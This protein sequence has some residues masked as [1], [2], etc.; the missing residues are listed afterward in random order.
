MSKL[1]LNAGQVTQLT[2]QDSNLQQA[3]ADGTQGPGPTDVLSPIN[4]YQR[5]STD[6]QKLTRDTFKM[7][8][9][10]F[11]VA[12]GLPGLTTTVNYRK[13]DGVSNGTLTFTNGILTS[14]T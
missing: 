14:S 9:A 3:F 6:L 1:T 4:G 12:M 13:S 2:T 8:L 5:L 10:A 7:T 11:M